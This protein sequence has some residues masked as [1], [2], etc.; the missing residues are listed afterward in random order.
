MYAGLIMES[1][2]TSKLFAA[3]HHPYTRGLLGCVPQLGKRRERLQT[4]DTRMIPNEAHGYQESFL[5]RC[6][7]PYAPRHRA[8][9]T[10]MEIAPGHHVRRWQE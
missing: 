7:P 8:L 4:L 3:P 9:P 1:A 5:D 6:P 10:L 2:P